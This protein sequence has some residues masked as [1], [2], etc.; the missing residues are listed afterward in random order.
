[1]KSLLLSFFLCLA[2]IT[3]YSQT[4][5][6][7]GT[8]SDKSG[9]PLPGVSIVVKNTTNGVTTDFDGNF[10]LPKIQSGETL[11][12]SY[13]GF[14]SKEIVVSSFKAMT[15]V[16]EDDT[17]SLEEV[18]VIGYG[19]QKVSQISGAVSTVNSKSVE[20]LKPVRAEDALQGQASGVNVISSGS[21][22]AKPTVL[23]RGIGSSSGNDPLVV[24]DGVT[25]TLDDLN[26]L[27]PSDIESMSVLKDAALTAIYGVSG[28]SGVI[29]VK[30]KSG[31]RSGKTTFSF[32]SSYGIQEV[33]KTIP[34]LNA[35]E[36]AAILNEASSNAGEGIIFDDISSLGAG[37]N[38]QDEVLIDAP[39]ITNN[40]TAAGGSENTSFFLSGGYLMQDGVVGGGD[41]SYFNRANVTAN[42]N[43]NLSEKFVFIAN[44]SYANIK[45]AGLSENNIGSVLSN[46]LNFDPMVSPY[47]ANGKFGISET[48]TQEIKNPLALIDSTYNLS[49][50]HI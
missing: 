5:E 9:N 37:T 6:I 42:F 34:V 27:N 33:T 19:T 41:K 48:I 24:I 31:K 46:A 28:G 43:T 26:S 3:M 7:Q 45:S 1:M 4:N 47:D 25:Q 12:F 40:I 23:I 49:L 16:L 21:P 38:W 2:S 29:V 17:Q 8:V 11:I 14:V 13:L 35:S 39:I 20:I 18:V 44:T 32:D 36:Y 15:V 50:I 22:G 10:T 30:T